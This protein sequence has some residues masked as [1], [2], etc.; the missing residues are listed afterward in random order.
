[1]RTLFFDIDGTLLV[2]QSAGSGA[3]VQAMR[4]EFEA[5]EA[6]A[7]GIRFGGRTDRDLVCEFLVAAGI[8]P[9][10]EN[11]GRLRRRYAVTLREVLR[12]VQG[13]VL[14]GVTE[15]LPAL[16]AT[17][18]VSLAVMT[19][20]FPETARMKLET[21]RLIDYFPWVVGGDLDAIRCDMARRAA[22]QLARRRGEAARDDVIVIGDTPNDV[23][24]AHS[25]GAKCLAVCTGTAS[26]DELESAGADRIVNDLTD[27]AAMEFLVG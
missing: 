19:G 16:S 13:N 12:T 25:I 18:H 15:L 27:Q 20:N 7:D 4:A 5:T 26:R 17:S 10:P 22:D 23:R 21:F 14:P 6:S 1:M 24:C 9:T 8:D 11:Q 3:L 2:T